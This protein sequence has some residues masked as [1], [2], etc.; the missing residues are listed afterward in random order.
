MTKFFKM[1]KKAY[2]GFIV[3]QREFFQKTLAMYNSRGPPA[4]KYQ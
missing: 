4:F 2:F 1:K 3:T